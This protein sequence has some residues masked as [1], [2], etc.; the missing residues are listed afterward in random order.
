MVSAPT[1]ITS[2][3]SSTAQSNSGSDAVN[4]Q[5]FLKLL[6][7][8]LQH[9]DPLNPAENQ[10]FV[11]E[12]ATFSSLEQQQ[13]QTQLLQKLIDASQSNNT[14]QAL[15]LIGR[16]VVVDEQRFNF[17]PGNPVQFIFQALQAGNAVIDIST[18]SGRLVYSDTFNIPSAGQGT[19]EFDGQ[20]PNGQ[21]LS[22]GTYNI[23]I[24]SVLD[25]QGEQIDYPTALQ[26]RVEG[27][28]FAAGEP[29][30]TVNGQAVSLGSVQS[31]QE[32][33]TGA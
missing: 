32:G 33:S 19:F 8:Q 12:L 30:L 26:G 6:I 2:T 10:E 4:R 11:A 15:S 27:V 31:I 23:S 14:S 20:L 1:N 5:D 7:A 13:L 22:S 17:T 3:A 16:N 21:I 29:K 25:N 28:S 18:D 24:H 9:Q